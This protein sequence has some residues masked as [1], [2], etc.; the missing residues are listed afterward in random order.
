MIN[1]I[2]S[3]S[4]NYAL[5]QASM[6]GLIK[7]HLDPAEYSETVS[8]RRADALNFSLFI[9]SQPDVLMS[10]GAADKNYFWR[11][12][13][14]QRTR[15]VKD[16]RHI[17]VPGDWLRR[18]IVRS[19]HLPQGKNQVHN[20]GWPRLDA[21][22][23]LQAKYRAS[24]KPA[25]ARPKVLWAPT[26]DLRRKGKELAISQSSYPKLLDD[27]PLLEKHVDLTSSLHPRNRD[28]KVPTL[29]QLIEADVVISDFGTMVYEAW[30]LGKP[31]IFPDWIVR[32]PIVTY[33]KP[34]VTERYIFDHNIGVHA[35]SIEELIEAAHSQRE[36]DET[37]RAFLD[38][39]IDPAYKGCSAKR[40]AD[41][42]RDL[43]ASE[44]AA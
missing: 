17:L 7:A 31:V 36:I 44:Q 29:E 23:A 26:H 41:F 21:L 18:R 27:L 4:P 19:K 32:D 10:H 15:L 14:E 16:V 30:A 11:R 38:G 20:V 13:P 6:L 39:Y 24:P 5:V 12:H 40:I 35:K 34:V 3:S 42:L 9:S 2:L 25:G 1:F 22:Y 43:A 8:R 37:T 28:S 33:M